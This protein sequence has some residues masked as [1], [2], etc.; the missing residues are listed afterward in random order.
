[1]NKQPTARSTIKNDPFESVIPLPGSESHVESEPV[2]KPEPAPV[3]AARNRRQ[4]IA[5]HL[6]PD[7][8]ERVKNAAYWNP[9]LTIAGI[10]E[11]GILQ[12]LQE[13]EKERGPYPPRDQELRGGRPIK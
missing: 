1:M 5:V 13:V 9:R 2:M 12:V 6:R 4:K 10:A 7:I 11:Q 8:I 3:K